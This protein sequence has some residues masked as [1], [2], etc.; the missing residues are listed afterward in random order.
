VAAVLGLVGGAGQLPGMIAREARRGGWRVVVFAL[1]DPGP[2]ATLADRVVPCRLGDVDTL[3]RVLGE[4]GI[5]HV[6]LSGRVWKDGLLRGDLALGETAR[7]LLRRS[8]DLSDEALLRTAQQVL[9]SLGIELLDPRRFL[10]PWLAPAGRLAGPPLPAAAIADVARGLALARE[11]ASR[12]VGQTVVIRSGSVA[13]VEAMEG[14]DV[15]IRRGLEL[16]GPGGVVVKA[17]GPEHDYRFDVPAIG[18]DTLA[19]CAAGRA[20]VLAVEA[21]GVLLVDREAIDELAGRAG[22]SV[23]GVPEPGAAG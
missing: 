12:G 7:L 10:G 20:A 8:P 23:V 3:L 9:E 16:A 18:R 2:L 17:A 21:G 19:A 22:I 11:L 13:A 1:D 6:A 15:A 14:T 4:E 5:R